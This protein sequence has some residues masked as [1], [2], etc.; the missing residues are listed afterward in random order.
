[1]SNKHS[2]IKI[3][4]DKIFLTNEDFIE[5]S[6]TNFPPPECFKFNSRLARYWKVE[7]KYS[8]EDNK[9]IL[10]VV[11]YESEDLDL[12]LTQKITKPVSFMKFENVE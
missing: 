3:F 2:I 6:Q 8:K 12:F 10:R 7:G 4:E 11:D 9:V 5:F 1:M